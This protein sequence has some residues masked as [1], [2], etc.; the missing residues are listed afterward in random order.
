VDFSMITG[1]T[2]EIAVTPMSSAFFRLIGCS[3]NR[4]LATRRFSCGEAYIRRH[5]SSRASRSYC[6]LPSSEAC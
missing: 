5:R 1:L 3:M 2:R 6:S 4:M